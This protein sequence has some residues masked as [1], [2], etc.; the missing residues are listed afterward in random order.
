MAIVDP[1]TGQPLSGPETSTATTPGAGAS[2]EEVIVDVTMENFQQV[3]LEGS[4]QRPVL[5]QSWASWCE[6]CKNLKPVLEKL[7]TEYAGAFVLARL[8]IEA[9]PQIASQ[10]GIRSVPDVKLIAQGQLYDQFQGALPE[11]QVREWLGKYIEAPDGASQSPEEMAQAA[12]AT[13]DTATAQAIYQ[14]LIQQ[15]PEHV[16]YQI[17]LAG[18][19][20]AGGQV[21]DARQILDG[22]PPEHRDAPKARGVRARLQF[23]EE[24]LSQAE[25]EALGERDDSEATYQRAMRLVADGDYENG[26]EAL[27]ALMKADRAYGEDAARKALLRVFDA[28]GADHP[29]TVTYRRKLFAMLY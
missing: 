6:P 7:A 1:R 4:M 18:V 8:D 27:L 29:L 3:V 2:A 14:E 19:L 20:L 5:L 24:A 10:L 13:G 28:L 12:L 17:D 15:Y 21:E 16:D 26:L 23:G 9:Y 11:S 25:I 22:L